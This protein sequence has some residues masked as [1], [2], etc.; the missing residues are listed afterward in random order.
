MKAFFSRIPVLVI[1]LFF[2]IVVRSQSSALFVTI[3]SD[4]RS[5]AL[6][7]AK[8][9]LPGDSFSAL[10]NPAQLVFLD[11]R[12]G[13]GY[14]YMPWM[15]SLQ[16]GQNLHVATACLNLDRKQ[17]LAVS[18]RYLSHPESE[19][20]DDQGNVLG[21][22]DPRDMAFDL[23]YARVIVRNFSGSVTCRYLSSYPGSGHA[24]HSVVLDAGLLYRHACSGSVVLAAGMQVSNLGCWNSEKVSLPWEL[25]V[26]GNMDFS[27]SGNHRITVTAD[28]VST[29]FQSLGGCVG[30]EYELFRALAFRGGYRW[31]DLRYGSVGT[32]LQWR[33]FAFDLGYLL[34]SRHSVMHKTWMLSARICW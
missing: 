20:I 8:A 2:P 26:G 7:G 15:A 30:L 28:L 27:P 16:S 10:R 3:P 29:K 31:S 9:A 32:G 33:Y 12:V 25:R 14:G 1:L 34:A 17:A 24:M 23:S 19:W 6:G 21:S 13:I 5:L 4:A 22:L 18:Y 11:G